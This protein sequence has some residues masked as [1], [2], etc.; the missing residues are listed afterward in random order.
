MGEE[1]NNMPFKVY[2]HGDLV[3][4]P[5]IE[6]S[7]FELPDDYDGNFPCVEHLETSFDFTI[8]SKSVVNSFWDIIFPKLHKFQVNQKR[9]AR[10]AKKKLKKQLE[11]TTGTKVKL[12]FIKNKAQQ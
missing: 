8:D 4:L 11:K 1:L 12:V 3:D 5:P 7:K 2:L 9:L 10:K 6:T